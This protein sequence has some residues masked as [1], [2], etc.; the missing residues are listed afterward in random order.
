MTTDT[1][2]DACEEEAALEAGE[3][4]EDAEWAEDVDPFTEEMKDS[5]DGEDEAA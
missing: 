5:A 3:E 1:M 4:A 2:Q